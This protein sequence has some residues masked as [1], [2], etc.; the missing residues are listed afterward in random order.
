[1]RTNRRTLRQRRDARSARC[2]RR[3]SSDGPSQMTNGLGPG[4]ATASTDRTSSTAASHCGAPTATTASTLPAC[5]RGTARAGRR[6]RG[7]GRP[8]PSP[9]VA[10]KGVSCDEG[11]R[12]ADVCAEDPLLLCRS[13]RS[14]SDRRS[15]RRPHRACQPPTV[16]MRF[17]SRSTSATRCAEVMRG[18]T[19]LVKRG[20]VRPIRR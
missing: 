11:G 10:S 9:T 16:Q 20:E 19:T 4:T 3:I 12:A 14:P 5:S 1:M 2:R 15:R 17:A 8:Q 6:N 18:Q 13:H 7:L